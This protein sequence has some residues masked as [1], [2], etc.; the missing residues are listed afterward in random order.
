MNINHIEKYNL[1]RGE[2]LEANRDILSLFT[3]TKSIE[4]TSDQILK[5][6][7]KS[8]RALQRK[9]IEAIFRIAVVGPLKSGKSTFVNSLLKGDYLKRGAGTVTSIITRVRS[10]NSTKAKLQ[11][12]SWEEV[13]SDIEEALVLFP[14]LKRYSEDSGFDIRQEHDRMVLQDALNAFPAKEGIYSDTFNPNMLL[15]TCYLKGYERVRKILSSDNLVK[16]YENDTFREH[17]D[18]VSQEPL[19]AYLKDIQLEV[20]PAPVA[21]DIE[22]GDCQGSDST[23]PLHITM[24]QDYLLSVNLIIYVISS[25]TG[26][27]RA[28]IRFLS[29]IRKMGIIHQALFVVNCDMSEHESY[30]ELL[31]IVDKV[32]E[33]I[34]FFKPDPE[35]YTI[36]AL[37]SLFKVIHPNLPAKDILRLDQWEKQEKFVNLSIKET[38]RFDSDFHHERIGKRYFLIFNNYAEH[39]GMILSG[40]NNWITINQ[41][42]LAR[43]AGDARQLIARIR[44]QQERMNQIKA[45]IKNTLEGAVPK[46]KQE[47]KT[48]TNRFFDFRSG[49]VLSEIIEFIKAYTVSSQKYERSLT[50]GKLSNTLYLVYQDFKQALDNTLAE[51]FQPELIRFA[52]QMEK[53][54]LSYF[55][56]ILDPYNAIVE[57]ALIESNTM[58]K[59]FGSQHTISHKIKSIELT[60][61]DSIKTISGLKLSPLV[62][63]L[64]YSAKIKTEGAIG[65]GFYA[66]VRVFK[67]IFDRQ[68]ADK[69]KDK[70][71][72]I[73]VILQRIKRETQKTLLD[74]CDNYREN[75]ELNYLCRLVDF[76]SNHLSETLLEHFQVYDTDL[77][78]TTGQISEGQIN[79]QKVSEILKDIQLM[80][81]DLIARVARIKEQIDE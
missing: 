67:K 47:I 50:T 54:I 15:L 58:R 16:E 22:I 6:Q 71:K 9:M 32:K 80:T 72:A 56:S 77:S 68:T 66:I 64:R 38:S 55:Q 65:L 18:F 59:E 44:Q 13:N 14:T 57:N 4:G 31:S 28:D 27:R 23:N 20:K 25:R 2:L 10:G 29:M 78:L 7:E 5:N 36:S 40:I 62:A 34:S 21:S 37:F 74:H 70:L 53:K 45:G 73:Q 1:I 39:Q 35:V 61:L 69:K 24:I 75:L 3:K 60:D 12:K 46:I 8:C 76:A 26:L 49:T 30:D 48:E 17:W 51:T 43:N 52:Q 33:E 41:E 42:I 11:F 19:S 63:Y 81:D 79:K